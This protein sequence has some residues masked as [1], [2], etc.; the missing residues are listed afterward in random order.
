MFIH[1][2]IPAKTNQQIINP[3]PFAGLGIQSLSILPEKDKTFIL[4][5]YMYMPILFF[6]SHREQVKG[7]SCQ[8]KALY[9]PKHH[10]R[11]SLYRVRGFNTA[12]RKKAF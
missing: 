11:S 9:K 3:F 4:I 5:L 1:T 2:N 8:K 6:L 12:N 10:V 7:N